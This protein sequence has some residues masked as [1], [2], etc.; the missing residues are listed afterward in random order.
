MEYKRQNEEEFLPHSTTENETKYHADP[1]P[2]IIR[3]STWETKAYVH[4]FGI[5][6]DRTCSCLQEY[7]TVDHLIY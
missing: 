2:N 7:Q 5:M 6:E 1:K 4:R 3:N